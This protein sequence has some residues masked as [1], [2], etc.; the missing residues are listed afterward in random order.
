MENSNIEL[1]R[2]HMDTIILRT[3]Q[4]DDKYGLEM[5]NEI[6]S[7]SEDLYSLKQPTLYSS[8]KRLE[9]QGYI[10][11]YPGSETKGANRTYYSLTEEGR[12]FLEADQKQW[13]FSRTI[14]D[15]LLSDKQFDKNDTPPFDPSEFRP[16][17]KREKREKVEPKIIYKYIRINDDNM[18]DDVNEEDI[19]DNINDINMDNAEIV[20]FPTLNKEDNIECN[21]TIAKEDTTLIE[22][23]EK[24][25]QLKSLMVM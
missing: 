13:E 5:L 18:P 21:E 10:T 24:N 14:I 4:D 22:K 23:K 1:I 9:K 7:L 15:K 6:R 11:S 20:D 25:H 2:G 19:I 12:Q 8:L 17:T 16:A 3:L